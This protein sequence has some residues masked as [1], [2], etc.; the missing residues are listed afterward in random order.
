MKARK[1]LAMRKVVGKLSGLRV[2]TFPQ[3]C[4]THAGFAYIEPT[5]IVSGSGSAK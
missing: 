4:E 5:K 1:S 3:I 2:K